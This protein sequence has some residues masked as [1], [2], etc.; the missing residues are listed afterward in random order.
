M[1][2]WYRK[3]KYEKVV[4]LKNIVIMFCA[5]FIMLFS[6]YSASSLI[7]RDTLN[8]NMVEY[9][10]MYGGGS[11]QLFDM[12]L[13][14]PTQQGE[15]RGLETFWGEYRFLDDYHIIQLKKKPTGSL[16]W[17][18]SNG[19]DIGNVYTAYRRWIHDFGIVGCTIILLVVGLFYNIVYNI[20]K[21]KKENNKYNLLLLFY[22]YMYYHLI[23]I[24]IDCRIFD[25]LIPASLSQFLV[26]GL[27]YYYAVKNN[28]KE[29]AEKI[30]LKLKQKRSMN[31]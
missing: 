29:S 2:L 15:V 4:K 11:I 14:N 26:S 10:T 27:I 28:W 31:K 18:K 24:S 16:E 1:I 30:I 20:L 6:F 13:Q 17:R 7:G 3:N 23:L 5:G 12:Y 8:N 19:Y 25:E 9:M 21:Y 22:A